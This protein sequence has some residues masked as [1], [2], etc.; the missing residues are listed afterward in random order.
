[1]VVPAVTPLIIPVAEPMIATA[2]EELTQVPPVTELVTYVAA[3]T[4]T[5]VAPAMGET[6]EI[7]NDCVDIQP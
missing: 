7:A 2:V 1:M 5:D 6:A 4:Q 3:P